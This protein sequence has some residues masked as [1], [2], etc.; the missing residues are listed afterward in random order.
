M[1]TRWNNYG[2]W[3]AIFALVG[4]IAK[5][6]LGFNFNGGQYQLYTESIMTILVL[7]GIINNPSIG[8]GYKDK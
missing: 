7:A 3:A 8:K 5:D 6:F 2:L 4:M 1:N